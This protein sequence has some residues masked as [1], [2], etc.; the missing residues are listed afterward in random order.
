MQ[1]QSNCLIF[2]QVLL[3]FEYCTCTYCAVDSHIDNFDLQING[4]VKRGHTQSYNRN[5]NSEEQNYVLGPTRAISQIYART[6]LYMYSRDMTPALPNHI[7]D[8]S[9]D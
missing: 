1:A 9:L 2:G 7:L 5:S 6:L 3:L 8:D 4:K